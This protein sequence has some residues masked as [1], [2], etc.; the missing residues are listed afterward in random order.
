MLEFI[1]EGQ[2]LFKFISPASPAFDAA[3]SGLLVKHEIYLSSASGFN[4]P[5]DIAPAVKSNLTVEQVQSCWEVLST[6]PWS[7]KLSNAQIAKILTA[8]ERAID[9]EKLK[10]DLN[11]QMLKSA[12]DLKESVGVSCFTER[13]DNLLLWSHYAGQHTGV[14]IEFKRSDAVLSA[15]KLAAQ[16]KYVDKRP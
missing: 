10:S 4:D 6:D 15:L 8:K 2:S 12:I 13:A 16:V 1:K 5:F 11:V 9:F 7:K 3:L 14:C